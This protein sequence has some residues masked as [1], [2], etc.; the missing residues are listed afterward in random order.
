MEK[1]RKRAEEA[2]ADAEKLCA[3]QDPPICGRPPASLARSPEETASAIPLPTA[4]RSCH[5]RNRERKAAEPRSLSG[6]LAS[7]LAMPVCV[8]RLLSMALLTF[9]AAG[10]LRFSL[11]ELLD[12]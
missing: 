1:A 12:F 10:D 3:R 4:D 2:G 7:G 6:S 11:N 9:T 5:Y 8:L